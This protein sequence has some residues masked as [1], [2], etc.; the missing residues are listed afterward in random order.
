MA[1]KEAPEIAA[2]RSNK[3]SITESILVGD[4]LH[5]FA[6]QLVEKGFITRRAAEGILDILATPPREKARK[7]LGSVFTKLE[8]ADDKKIWFDKFVSIFSGEPAYEELVKKL[9]KCYEGT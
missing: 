2:I 8:N 6:D 9:G 5:W 7:L 3:E 1:N 4:T